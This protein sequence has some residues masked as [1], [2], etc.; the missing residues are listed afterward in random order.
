M[1]TL[2]IVIAG[3]LFSLMPVADT[4]AQDCARATTPTNKTVCHEPDLAK[5]DAELNQLYSELRP[6]LTVRARGELLAQQRAWLAG[7]NRDCATGVA[8]CLRTKY[9]SRID[10]LQA[11]TA[12][13]AVPDDKLG[14]LDTVIVRGKW[15]A[16]AIKDPAGGGR[17]SEGDLRNA[18]KDAGLPAVGAV[19]TTAP[20]D[21]CTAT[22]D[23]GQMAWSR[24]TL[25]KT[26]GGESIG[27]VFGLKMTTVILEGDPGIKHGIFYEFL[28]QSDGTIWAVFG[29]C[30]TN[31]SDCW[32]TAEVL[33]PA[34]PDAGIQLHS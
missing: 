6:Q 23:C 31:H 3:C 14:S 5:M 18:L 25:A 33:T 19:L 2:P 10:W 15:K 13:A 27:R 7:R 34:S 24:T 21:I 20:G 1:K 11:L 12:A 29:L 17:A 22:G 4:V 16:T 8:V 9:Q 32:N 28:P 26:S 30:T